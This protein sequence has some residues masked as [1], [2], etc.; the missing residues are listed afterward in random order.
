MTRIRKPARDL[1]PG[2][3]LIG[4]LANLKVESVTQRL[5]G[6]GWAAKH[7]MVNGTY[8][9]GAVDGCVATDIPLLPDTDVTV[10]VEA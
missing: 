2:D 5:Y 9:G 7:V 6:G 3:L 8:V 4:S 10:E 1:E